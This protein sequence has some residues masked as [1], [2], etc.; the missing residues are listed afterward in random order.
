MVEYA[1]EK[2]SNARLQFKVL[3]FSTKDIEDVF[4]EK[5]FSKLFSFY[6]L[7]WIQDQQ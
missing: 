2:Y 5:P 7:H 3:D 4:P 6:C 1:N